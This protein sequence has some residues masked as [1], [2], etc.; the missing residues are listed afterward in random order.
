MHGCFSQVQLMRRDIG[1]ITTAH[2][3][4]AC[5]EQA[6]YHHGTL[7]SQG[8]F[9]PRVNGVKWHDATIW[10]MF[11]VSCLK[12]LKQT[13]KAN[14]STRK[15]AGSVLPCVLMEEQPASD[16]AGNSSAHDGRWR[17]SEPFQRR[18]HGPSRTPGRPL[19]PH[20]SR[21]KHAACS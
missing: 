1:N 12:N 7:L 13:T 4:A 17:R 16:V 20:H 3:T 5:R 6:D 11:A 2:G 18:H 10:R 8:L 19:T 14:A 21:P 9:G 15:I